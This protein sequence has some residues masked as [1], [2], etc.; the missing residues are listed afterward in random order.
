MR[1]LTQK[2]AQVFAEILVQLKEDLTRLQLALDPHPPLQLVTA[3][4]EED[5]T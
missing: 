5:D 1:T 2:E 3:D 4:G